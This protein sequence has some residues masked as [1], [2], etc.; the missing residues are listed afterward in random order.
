[1]QYAVPTLW[2]R[3]VLERSGVRELLRLPRRAVRDRVWGH[4]LRGLR[5]RN[6]R[7]IPGL[8][9][10]WNVSSRDVRVWNRDDGVPRVRIGDVQHLLGSQR[11]CGHVFT[12]VIFVYRLL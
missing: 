5:R 8:Q 4:C 10:L 12:W 7:V 2:N 3:D 6:V 9:L 1:M 11:L